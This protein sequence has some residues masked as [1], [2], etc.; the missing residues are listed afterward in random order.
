MA[1]LLAELSDVA[2]ELGLSDE[3]AMSENQIA[4][5]ELLLE[6]VSSLFAQEAQRDFAPGTSTVRLKVQYSTRRRCFVRLSETPSLVESMVNEFDVAITEFQVRQREVYFANSVFYDDYFW[7]RF[8][9]SVYDADFVTVTYV[10]ND[11][12]PAGVRQ[13][14]AGIAARYIGLSDATGSTTQP[15]ARSLQAGGGI[16]TYSAG[17]ADWVTQSPQLTPE[18]KAMARSYRHPA[19]L[20]IVMGT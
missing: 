16:V 11:P 4:R 14:V 19:S 9:Q 8:D 13:A 17:Y 10:H 15:S 12:I 5:A 2:V 20:P 18:D 1:G 3:S 7:G 6:R